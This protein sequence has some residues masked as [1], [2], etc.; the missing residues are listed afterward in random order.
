MHVGHRTTPI[1]LV[2]DIGCVPNSLM[3]L[4]GSQDV[5]GDPVVVAESGSDCIPSSLSQEKV[6]RGDGGCSVRVMVMMAGSKATVN[7]SQ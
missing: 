2:A 1:S 4:S 6:E 7:K 3:S 5:C